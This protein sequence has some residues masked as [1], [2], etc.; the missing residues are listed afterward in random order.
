VAFSPVRGRAFSGS[1]DGITRLWDLESGVE[2]RRFPGGGG[3][4]VDGV[5]C[6]PKGD[7][8]YTAGGARFA[9]RAWNV[10]AGSQI[11]QFVGHTDFAQCLAVSPDGRLLLSG[12]RD[13]TVRLWDAATGKELHC[14][15]GHT[16]IVN[17]VTFSPDGRKALSGSAD[18]TIKVWD[19]SAFVPKH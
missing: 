19:L 4:W 1:E 13:D 10:E 6:S 2:I 8:F 11:R 18:R 3:S 7:I 17:S 12:G 9:L 14:F 5:A 16:A 15:R